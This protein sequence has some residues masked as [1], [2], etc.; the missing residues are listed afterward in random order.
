MDMVINPTLEN[1]KITTMSL[2]IS[3]FKFPVLDEILVF[4]KK[5][6]LKAL[7]VKEMLNTIAPGQFEFIKIKDNLLDALLIRKYLLL[8]MEKETLVESVAEEARQF[9]D[10]KCIVSIKCNINVTVNRKF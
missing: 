4:A 6:P 5:C 2:E 7:A 10:K 1:K 8:R 9:M 3:T